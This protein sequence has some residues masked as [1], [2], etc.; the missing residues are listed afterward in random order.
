M[1][2]F[3]ALKGSKLLIIMIEVQ[4]AICT[5]MAITTKSN[6]IHIYAKKLHSEGEG[7]YKLCFRS[8]PFVFTCITI[9]IEMLFVNF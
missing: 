3:F 4:L 7:F 5:G 1:N 9:C 6:I 8:D 2:V